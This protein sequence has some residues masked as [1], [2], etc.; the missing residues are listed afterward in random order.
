MAS[1][2]I[3]Q[4]KPHPVLLDDDTMAAESATAVPSQ[5]A[6]KIYTDNLVASAIA[7]GVTYIGDYDAATNTP[8][9][10]TSPSGIDQGDMYVVSVA[11]VFFTANVEVGDQLIAKQDNPTAE[12]HWSIVQA[13]L[14]AATIKTQYESNPDTN[15]FNDAE[16]NKTRHR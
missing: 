2:F 13:N 4:N 10:D 11:G 9:L 1:S 14:D 12:A 5:R 6:A 7:G 8:D 16:K 3:P 15:E